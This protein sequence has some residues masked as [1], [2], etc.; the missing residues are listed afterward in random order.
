MLVETDM[1]H[2]VYD[3]FI[4]GCFLRVF[5]WKLCC[6][7]HE[8]GLTEV[9]QYFGTPDDLKLGVL[10]LL[11]RSTIRLPE[12]QLGVLE[13][14]IH[15]IFNFWIPILILWGTWGWP[16]LHTYTGHKQAYGINIWCWRRRQCLHVCIVRSPQ[17]QSWAMKRFWRSGCT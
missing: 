1:C 5:W 17:E 4:L 3:V 9:S 11:L 14:L 12:Q 15:S 6:F 7:F 2:Q 8:T 10:V 16:E 13:E